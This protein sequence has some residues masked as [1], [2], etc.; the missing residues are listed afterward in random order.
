MII[1]VIGIVVSLALFAGL[2]IDFEQEKWRIRPRQAIAAVVFAIALVASMVSFVPTGYTG[3][4]T[5]FGKVEDR[6]AQAGINFIAPWQKVVKM[7]NRTQKQSIE[8]SAFSSDIQQ[9]DITMTLNYKI[10]Q[11]TA[12]T[13]YATV[14][15]EYYDTIL[16]PRALD[17]IKTVFA[18]YSAE[19]LVTNRSILGDEVA[20]LIAAATEAYGIEITGVSIENIDFTDAFTDAVE[21]K[22]VA[23]QNKLTA[24]TEQ[25]RITMEAEAEAARQVIA[26]EAE[27]EILQIQA[28][29]AKYAGEKEAEANKKLAESL[30][31]ELVEYYYANKWDG[32]LPE[33]YGGE[34]TIPVLNFGSSD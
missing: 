24:E 8:T 3:I 15:K 23:T 33:Y 29:A 21:A 31:P 25:A 19:A 10:D 5:S 22:Q 16:Y 7:D 2:G 6:T 30:T 32:V 14:G 28:E 12:Q 27:A 26:A 20:S 13:L 18:G 9:V 4:L 17:S 11:R 34:G 1:F